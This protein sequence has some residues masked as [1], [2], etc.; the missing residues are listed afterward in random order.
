[1]KCFAKVFVISMTFL[2]GTFFVTGFVY[3]QIAPNPNTNAR[4]SRI[5]GLWDVDVVVANC[6]TGT[7]L[8]SF[9]ALH[10]YEFGGT[11]QVVPSTN[12][13]ALS[14]HMMIWN[15]VTN[16]DYQMALKMYRFDANGANIG[17]VVLQNEISIS[18]NGQDYVGSGVANMYNTQG[19]LLGSSCPSFVGTRFTGE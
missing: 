7:P 10:K 11:G 17:W 6:A 3:A 12:P 19:T 14:A 1:M 8:A 13:T 2:I 5:V 18:E 16:N 4:A 9:S 15:H